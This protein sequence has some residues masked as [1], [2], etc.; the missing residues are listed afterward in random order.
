[1]FFKNQKISLSLSL[2]LSLSVCLSLSLPPPQL[3]VRKAEADLLQDRSVETFRVQQQLARL[4]SRLDAQHEAEE[5]AEAERL[6][7]LERLEAARRRSYSMK[8]RHGDATADGETDETRRASETG[9]PHLVFMRTL[10]LRL[11]LFRRLL[12]L[13]LPLLLLLLRSV[14]VTGA[15]E[16]P[17][18]AAHL[19]TRTQ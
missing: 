12:L 9:E 3:A 19:H 14:P 16:Q 4:Q 8:G 11:R 17:D 13:R 6:A 18:A 15:D 5:R 2:P 10:R 1:V 7:A